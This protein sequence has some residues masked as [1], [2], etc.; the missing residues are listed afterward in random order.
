MSRKEIPFTVEDRHAYGPLVRDEVPVLLLTERPFDEVR[1]KLMSIFDE[2]GEK[3]SLLM[4]SEPDDSHIAIFQ[5]RPAKYNAV[6][7]QVVVTNLRDKTR[8]SIAPNHNL[9]DSEKI[10]VEKL[11]RLVRQAI[12]E[13]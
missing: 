3:D 5:Y 11:S 9:W 2:L 7:V 8:L 13:E 12:S 10:N 1:A 4:Q 6:L